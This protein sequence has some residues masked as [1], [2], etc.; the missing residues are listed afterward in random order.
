M[1]EEL[2]PVMLTPDGYTTD[3]KY[4]LVPVEPSDSQALACHGSLQYKELYQAAITASPPIPAE[5]FVGQ[6]ATSWEAFDKWYSNCGW[7]YVSSREGAFVVWKA[8]IALAAIKSALGE[9]NDKA[10]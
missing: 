8:A 2:K 6:E 4:K 3:R 1:T 5:Y 7:K 9:D 10:P